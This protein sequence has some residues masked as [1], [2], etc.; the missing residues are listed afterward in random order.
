MS[1]PNLKKTFT[2]LTGHPPF[3]WQERLYSDWFLK[4][5]VPD[6]CDIPTGLGKTSVIALWLIAMAAGAKLPRRLV[7][8]VNRRTVV[9]QTTIEVKRLAERLDGSGLSTP[10]QALCGIPLVDGQPPL[11]VSTLRGQFADNQ[12]WFSDPSRPAV[13]CGTVDMIGSRLLFS[14]YRIGFKSRPLHAGFLGQDALLVH[15]EAHLEPAFQKLIEAIHCE[16]ARARTRNGDLPWPGLRVMALSA[17]ARNTAENGEGAF[18]LT[19]EEKKPPVTNPNPPTEPIHHVWRRSTAK[20]SLR[21]HAIDDEKKLADKVA[22]LALTHKDSSAAVLIFVRTIDDVNKVGH[23]L[24][25]KKNG[26]SVDQ[27]RQL[28]G[29]MRGYERDGLVRDPAF[30]RFLPDADRPEDVTP[31]EGTVYLVCT[32]AGEVGVNLS[33]DHIVCDLST[34]DSMVQRFGRV[35]RFGNCI[36][37]RIDVVHPNSFDDNDTLTPVRRATLKLLNQLDG[38]A[39]P[40]ALTRLRSD[41]TAEAFSPEPTILPATDILFDAWAMTSIRGRMPGRPPV[42]EYLHG[43]AEWEPPRTSVAWRDDVERI[44]SRMLEDYGS[45]FPQSLLDDYPLKPH[46]LLS[47]VSTRVLDALQ[48]IQKRRSTSEL[49]NLWIVSAQGEMA[50]TTL[51]TLLKNDK[52]QILNVLRDATI[53]LPPNAGGL[54]N[55]LLDGTADD[56]HD[57]ADKWVNEQDSPRRQRLLSDSHEPPPPPDNMTLIR[58]VDLA[59]WNDEQALAEDEDDGSEPDAESNTETVSDE[60]TAGWRYWHWFVRPRDVE[61]ATLASRKPITWEHHTEDV[62]QRTAQIVDALRFPDELKRALVLA[63]RLHDLGKKRQMWQRAIGNPTPQIWYAKPGK[64]D[65]GPAWQPRTRNDYR[66]EFGSLLDAMDPE[67][68]YFSEVAGL[69]PHLQDVVLHLIATHHGFARP[70]FLAE[71]TIDLNHN[72]ETAAKTAIDVMRRYARLQQRYGRWGLAYLE[73]ILRAADWSA[74]ANPSPQAEEGNS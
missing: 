64:P 56:A 50:V 65:D 52:K 28:T 6:T 41:Q 70:H 43:V 39:S 24:T 8:V 9:D 10:L 14:G 44:N 72:S 58:T 35:N 29:T 67:Q 4:G 17:T 66:H 63:A 22:D 51:D 53:L 33:A 59:P 19:D 11:A 73:S 31:A 36:N 30:I 37:T 47:D 25:D 7:Y 1:E 60:V 62:V 16:Q 12:E 13:I 49:T 68:E 69:S 5:H 61:N 34:F 48:K 2:D 71:G 21:L 57:V 45:D 23:K 38:D 18:G 27:V 26:V 55:G 32:S 54:A 15:D 74:S 42:A 20:K 46:E 3:P 40:L